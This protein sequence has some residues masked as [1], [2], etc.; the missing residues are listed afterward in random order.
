MLN[1]ALKIIRTSENLSL[2]EASKRLNLSKSHISE[3]ENGLKNP[4]L[5]TIQKYSE[6]F[7]IPAS[8]ILFFSEQMDQKEG[9]ISKKLRNYLSDKI[10][11][12]TEHY[13]DNKS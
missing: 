5:E 13:I 7:D 10:I 11:K 4:S 8:S 12:F 2:S 1:Q 9:K 6:A 3:L